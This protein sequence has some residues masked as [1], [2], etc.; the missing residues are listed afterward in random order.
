MVNNVAML[1]TFLTALVSIA[2][3]HPILNRVA[4]TPNHGDTAWA[5]RPGML[6]DYLGYVIYVTM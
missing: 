4:H 3:S 2:T 1:T 6:M 5:T